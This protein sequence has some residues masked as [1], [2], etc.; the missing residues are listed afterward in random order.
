MRNNVLLLAIALLLPCPLAFADL[1]K[2]W[3]TSGSQQFAEG[4]LDG[5]SVLSTGEVELAP[6]VQK[7]EGLQAEFVWD[8]EAA[9]DGTVYVGTGGPAAVYALNGDR[10]QLLQKSEDKQVLSLLPLPDGSLLFATAPQGVIYRI[11]RRGKTTTFADLKEPYIWHMAL[12]RRNEIYC[13]TGPNGKLIELSLLGE[14]KELL[15][16]KQKNLLSV[17]VGK[18]GTI[19]TG[20]DT[21]GYVYSIAPNG[22][23]AVIYQADESEVHA[24]LT[25]QDDAVYVCTAQ[26]RPSPAPGGQ[27]PMR[28]AR[29]PEATEPTTPGPPS[30][31]EAGSAPQAASAGAAASAARSGGS[32][33]AGQPTPGAYN[34]IYRIVPNQGGFLV[35]RF[36]RAFVL[37]LASAGGRVVAG[38]GP[39]A[40]LV[41]LD[42]DMQFRILTQFDAGF[43][44]TMTVL[45]DGELIA[46][47]SHAGNLYRV[48]PGYRQAGSFVSKAFDAGY[49]SRWGTVRW[50]QKVEPGQGIRLKVRTGNSNEPDDHWSDWTPW[51]TEPGGQDLA[52]PM[53]RYAQ[54]QAELSRKSSAASPALIDVRLSYRQANRR[55]VIE[56]ITMEGESLLHRQ[57]RSVPS[58]MERPQL[59]PGPQQPR[60]QRPENPAPGQKTVSW[61]ATDPN[62]DLMAVD[63]YYRGVDETEWKKLNREQIRNESSYSWDTSR[64]PDGYYVLKLT[65]GDS[66]VRPK[67]E[68]LTDEKVTFP[69]L[70]DNTPP[71]VVRL[72]ARRQPDGSYVLT[73]TAED[74]LS[75]IAKIEV[76]HNA[77]DWVPVFPSDGIFDS[78]QEPFSYTTKALAPGEHVF[79]FAATDSSGNTGSAKIVVAVQAP[80]K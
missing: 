4:K 39:D 17:A 66:P 50:Q 41:A 63:L 12:G 29:P 34:S 54:F 60:P 8:V 20:T 6:E 40:R 15:K 23:A 36:D 57:E 59:R 3:T 77:E 26:S 71:V 72:A 35:G 22:K 13:A 10:L 37:S 70:I 47:T 25:G 28:A 68:A 74:T 38:I 78:P 44:M 2:T 7:I 33:A 80:G 45:P 62:D 19:Y 24:I 5:V 52:V 46:G 31:G 27:P 61:K 21:G 73:G 43:V 51:A 69:V 67:D 9:A 32:A 56:D 55:P 14:A 49:L 79:V 58:P 42:K 16:V 48:K 76:S 75:Q 64:V 1:G 18:D 53:G 30:P 65:A 11:D